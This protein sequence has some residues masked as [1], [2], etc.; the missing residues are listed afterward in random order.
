MAE[1]YTPLHL[2]LLYGG[3]VLMFASLYLNRYWLL[4]LLVGIVVS[5]A[6]MTVFWHGTVA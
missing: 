2:L 5:V 6:G 3:F 1:M 4:A